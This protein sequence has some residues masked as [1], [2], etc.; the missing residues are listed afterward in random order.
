[1]CHE[2]TNVIMTSKQNKPKAQNSI[3]IA[4][5]TS[6]NTKSLDTQEQCSY[7][8]LGLDL[9][10]PTDSQYDSQFQHQQ[11]NS[12]HSSY[13]H[14]D[15]HENINK[16]ASQ[17]SMQQDHFH[18][19]CHS[20]ESMPIPF[21]F[22]Q[23]S[24]KPRPLSWSNP[25]LS[26]LTT[27]TNT[28]S[29][30]N[31]NNVLDSPIQI[32]AQSLKNISTPYTAQFKET[33]SHGSLLTPDT[34]MTTPTRLPSIRKKPKLQFLN[35]ISSPVVG[36]EVG[37]A[38]ESGTMTPINQLENTKQIQV[39]ESE[40]SALPFNFDDIDKQ[41]VIRLLQDPKFIDY[42]CI[43]NYFYIYC[44]IIPLEIKLTTPFFIG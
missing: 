40:D 39:Y 2:A 41:K 4:A 31:I 32:D 30:T 23:P 9:M 17:E 37:V 10:T 14:N 36:V 27:N 8:Q 24:A 26:N 28:I 13:K 16:S 3:S 12:P 15:K 43:M 29:G 33:V 25:K 7:T 20:V 35:P 19:Q 6:E 5:E 1:M 34:S 22:T 21:S 38:N 42:V 44:S 18:K 11:I